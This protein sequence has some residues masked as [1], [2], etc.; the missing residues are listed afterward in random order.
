MKA[1]KPENKSIVSGQVL[2]Y[3]YHFDKARLVVREMADALALELV[4]KDLV[5]TD[6]YGRK[7]PKH[8]MGTENF[9]PYTSSLTI[10]SGRQRSSTTG[11]W[12]ETCW[13]AA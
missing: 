12:T 8:A 7:I 10:S 6:R 4:D 3:P 5:T 9:P 1:Y 13:F 11:L 2:Q